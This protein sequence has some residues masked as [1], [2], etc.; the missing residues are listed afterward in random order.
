MQC[1]FRAAHFFSGID[2]HLAREGQRIYFLV[3]LFNLFNRNLN[4]IIYYTSIKEKKINSKIYEKPRT[5]DYGCG[6]ILSDKNCV[7]LCVCYCGC[8]NMFGVCVF[9]C[10]KPCNKPCSD[11]IITSLLMMSK[12]VSVMEI[13]IFVYLSHQN[14]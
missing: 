10:N 11:D 6:I 2:Q 13:E 9:V 8:V 4:R 1:S 14:H 5:L 3:K 12:I 7:C